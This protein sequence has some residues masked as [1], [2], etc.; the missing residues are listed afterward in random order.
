MTPRQ[1]GEVPEALRYNA[2][3][4]LSQL[5]R[6][7]QAFR[8]ENLMGRTQVL[9]VAILGA[10]LVSTLSMWFAATRS[11]ATVD[12]VL[13]RAHPQFMEATKPLGEGA[14][15]RVLRYLA[16]EINRTLFWG[17]GTLQI[18]LGAILFLLLWR[19]TP[20]DAVGLG[21]AATMLA[22]V[23]ILTFVITPLIISLG[24]DLDF[25]PRTPPPPVLPRFWALHGSFTG[26]DGVKFLA[27]LGL[28]IRWMFR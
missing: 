8:S 5:K 22:L 12:S 4:S 25:V 16:S 9:A 28:L 1:R 11:F 7:N 6:C 20:R 23:A 26:L 18:T 19:Q 21:L 2:G 10:W 24:R 13:R 14:T 15:C 17:Y 3:A 27:G